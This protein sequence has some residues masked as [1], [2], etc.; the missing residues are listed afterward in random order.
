LW[1]FVSNYTNSFHETGDT[2]YLAAGS[3]AGL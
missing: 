3:D 2:E 1:V